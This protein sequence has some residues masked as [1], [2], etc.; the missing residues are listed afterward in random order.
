MPNQGCF[1]LHSQSQRNLRY[2]FC[3]ENRGY[4]APTTDSTIGNNMSVNK[5]PLV[6]ANCCAALAAQQLAA[7]GC[8]GGA[9]TT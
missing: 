1:K 3:Y 4:T 9:L 7:T 8:K 6:A 2:I 5:P